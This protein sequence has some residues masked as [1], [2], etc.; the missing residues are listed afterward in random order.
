MKRFKTVFRKSDTSETSSHRIWRR[1][2]AKPQPETTTTETSQDPVEG[3]SSSAQIIS[4]VSSEVAPVGDV[5]VEETPQADPS[6][7]AD[8]ADESSRS[9]PGSQRLKKLV[10]RF[11]LSGSQEDDPITQVSGPSQPEASD[12]G[13]A[14]EQ[15]AGGPLSS[16]PPEQLPGYE[17]IVAR[18]SSQIARDGRNVG[19][20]HSHS[21][22]SSQTEDISDQPPHIPETR[23]GTSPLDED[24]EDWMWPG[25]MYI[26]EEGTQIR[27]FS[28]PFSDGKSTEYR[29]SNPDKRP[30]V[31]GPSSVAGPSRR[32]PYQSQD[33]MRASEG[34]LEPISEAEADTIDQIQRIDHAVAVEPPQRAPSQI[35]PGRPRARAVSA[36]SASSHNSTRN[37]TPQSAI[38]NFNRMAARHGIR[39]GIASD[40]A[41]TPPQTPVAAQAEPTRRGL[42]SRLRNVRSNLEAAQERTPILRRMRTFGNLRPA[43][44]TSLRGR[45]LEELSRLG[46]HSYI[47]SN[48][49][50]PSPLQL[51][52]S[53][54]SA[55]LFLYTYGLNHGQIF[56]QSGDLK[57]AA[58][59]YDSWAKDVFDAENIQSE[60]ELTTRVIALPPLGNASTRVLSVGWALKALLAGLPRGILGSN[61]L[62]QTLYNL[63][64]IT[65]PENTGFKIPSHFRSVKSSVAVRV[66]LISLALI[67]LASEMQR[68]LIC[69]TFGL[70]T[71]LLRPEST[72]GR[73]GSQ[74]SQGPRPLPG[75]DVRALVAPPE[76]LDLVRV[77]APLLLGQENR[78]QVLEGVEQVEQE[79][80]ESR[81]CTLL[82]DHWPNV[83]RQL[84]YWLRDAFIP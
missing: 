26:P 70:L 24:I 77:F 6:P 82:L 39:V 10:T 56:S 53:I 35:I 9:R 51:P 43:P 59:V 34:P 54:V 64:A 7:Q 78:V 76:Y 58:R 49:L 29:Q 28:D 41:P 45:T 5:V 4:E 71:F 80:D 2:A 37:L 22:G 8:V 65:I 1:S 67:G 14:R 74:R 11:R 68:D 21:R 46:G 72:L 31:A 73:H 12:A 81:V 79:L 44:F 55:I 36:G 62:Y 47:V 48:E 20:R 17:N 84:Q 23:L 30:A 63:F 50:G 18:T 66:Q 38:L 27:D 83:H 25:L 40:E 16:N 60:I 52:A 42:F 57:T 13:A 33:E 32:A 3:G 15:A 75:A 69:A 61:R 19:G